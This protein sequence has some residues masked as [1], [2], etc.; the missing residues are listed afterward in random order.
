M[1]LLRVSATSKWRDVTHNREYEVM[2][3][4]GKDYYII[5]DKGRTIRVGPV[6]MTPSLWLLIEDKMV[7]V[8]KSMLL[9]AKEIIAHD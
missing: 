4:D 3:K 7:S 5:D 2:E 6:D 8:P 1:K 9:R